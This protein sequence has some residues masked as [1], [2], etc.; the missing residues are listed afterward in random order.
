MK[1]R[2]ASQ[3]CSK[4]CGRERAKGQRYCP[5]HRALAEGARRARKSEE[6]R[7]LLADRA[8]LAALLIERFN[9]GMGG[10]G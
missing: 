7:A 2:E 6:F 3:L 9:E 5:E 4:G 10:A 8:K 1:Y